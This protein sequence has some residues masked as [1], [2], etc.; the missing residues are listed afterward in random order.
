MW[1]NRREETDRR[2]TG[3]MKCW[4]VEWKHGWVKELLGGCKCVRRR[5]DKCMDVV[6]RKSYSGVHW[7]GELI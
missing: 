1:A 6:G 3:R 7:I 4:K 2:V 5:T